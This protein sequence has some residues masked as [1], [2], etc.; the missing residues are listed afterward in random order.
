MGTFLKT[1][2]LAGVALGL[3][4][5]ATWAGGFAVRE[6]SAEAQGASFAG[7]AAGTDGLSAMF[8]NPATI[9]LHGDQGYTSESNAALIL[10]FSEA[11]DGVGAGTPDS[12]NIGELALVPASY[13]V[14]GVNDQLTI[15]ASMNAPFG[16]T[17]NANDGWAGAPHGDK[18][19]VA[20]YNFSPTVAYELTDWLTV[21]AGAQIEYMTVGL[22]S[23]VA[24]TQI[25]EADAD[26]LGFGF[27]AGVLLQPTDS[28]DIGLGFRSSISHKLKGDGLVTA[29]FIPVSLQASYDSPEMVTLGVRQQVTEQLAL[30]GGVEWTNW[31]RFE[32]LTLVNSGTGGVIGTTVENWRDGW[33]FSAGAEYAYSDTL[34]LR[35]GVAYEK[36]PVPDATRTPRVPDNDRYWLSIGATY[37]FSDMMTAHVAYSHVFMDDG[38]I[39]LTAG[40]V[41]PLPA[42]SASFEQSLD[43][44]SAGLTIDW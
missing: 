11:E 16:L 8:W 1:G 2:L 36:S 13:W 35:G 17:T 26:S 39:N 43:I 18:S 41:P 34:T 22:T 21:A 6:Q 19:A 4:A 5:G 15:G 33:Y 9:S 7:A 42:L 10:P 29:G 27:T 32:E 28:L 3:L 31:S 40:G 14:Y 23:R 24:G 38:N 25:L 12:G 20:T 30:L 37:K 44:V